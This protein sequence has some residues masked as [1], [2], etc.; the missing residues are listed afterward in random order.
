MRLSTFVK[1]R[2]LSS[3]APSTAPVS[4]P[5]NRP[6]A[7]SAPAPGGGDFAALLDSAPTPEPAAAPAKATL[8]RAEATKAGDTDAD[9]ADKAGTAR[10]HTKD[11]AN[12]HVDAA[13]ATADAPPGATDDS[14]DT[15]AT[16]TMVAPIV[17][18]PVTA[19]VPSAS[20]DESA[21]AA[22]PTTT[23]TQLALAAIGGSAMPAPAT[24][25]D[26]AAS[27][28]TPQA[29]PAVAATTTPAQTA[30]GLV[31][32]TT[33]GTIAATGA[34]D[35]D[36]T[37]TPAP[38]LAANAA[39]AATTANADTATEPSD[40]ADD[41]LADAKAGAAP[42]SKQS[43]HK[44]DAAAPHGTENGRAGKPDASTGTIGAAVEAMPPPA[45]PDSAS[46]AGTAPALSQ[47]HLAS[48]TAAATATPQVAMVP[49]AVAVP[50]SGLALTIASQARA[51]HSRFDI[52][53]DPAE[54]GR[55]DVRLSIDRHGA[56]TSH[57]VVEK[58]ETLDLL[59]RDAQQLQRALDDAGLKTGSGGLQFSLR[60]HA[61][62]QRDD[63]G[64]RPQQRIVIADDVI[65]AETAGRNYGQMPRASGGLDIRV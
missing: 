64:A 26:P 37:A 47:P 35:G 61:S 56:V 28:A 52:Q 33:L 45:T 29:E 3:V 10:N 51:G 53:L 13:H 31:A 5:A 39:T 1:G 6:A 7:P 4:A 44:T 8:D 12:N 21:D 32:A 2:P 60:D 9:K 59:R 11:H 18:A 24:S 58:A 63:G 27:T 50:L 40:T 34:G 17:P 43:A 48:A 65:A 30:T 42:D 55:I 23:P 22:A 41:T 20:A 15:A 25:G 46:P 16:A 49:P 57:V 54:L 38:L 36:A 14:A 19:P 62:P